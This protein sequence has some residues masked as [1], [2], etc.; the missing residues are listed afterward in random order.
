MLCLN[1]SEI[2]QQNDNFKIEY[3]IRPIN[4]M[5]S[6]V[7][8][9]PRY[10]FTLTFQLE[11]IPFIQGL[12]ECLLLHSQVAF[13]AFV[14][15]SFSGSKVGQWSGAANLSCTVVESV[16]SSNKLGL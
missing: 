5:L 3:L 16:T 15:T 8:L 13:L 9:G 11:H 7:Q 6:K 2:L 4:T 12:D 10:F 1:K 14:S